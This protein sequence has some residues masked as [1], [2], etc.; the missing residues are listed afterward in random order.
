MA[1]LFSPN[2]F[3][4]AVRNFVKIQ[5]RLPEPPR[6]RVPLPGEGS[7]AFISW[8]KASD[9]FFDRPTDPAQDTGTGFPST[10]GKKKR[11]KKPKPQDNQPGI[12]SFEMMDAEYEQGKIYNP[13][14]KDQ[15][16]KVQRMKS[17][18]FRGPDR[19]IY[20]FN[21]RHPP[22][23]KPPSTGSGSTT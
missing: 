15:W 11:E 19:V 16:V 22:W 6:P 23:P 1:A 10:T 5:T 3:E 21:F 13:D 9:F 2:N 14:D 12:R 7:E 20:K 18:R 8:G 4:R 17:V